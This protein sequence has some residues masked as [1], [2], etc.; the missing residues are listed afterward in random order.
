MV[1]VGGSHIAV[2]IC[3]SPQL[4]LTHAI[5]TTLPL[6]GSTDAFL[7]ALIRSSQQ[8][9]GNLHT[10][11][12]AAI[13]IAG[14]F[15]YPKGISRMR[16][17]LEYLYGFGMKAAIANHFGWL[18]E[19]VQFLN[20]ADA[21]LLGEIGTGAARLAT[22]SVG[23]TLGT[24]IG[25]AFALNGQLVTYGPGVPERGEVWD[26]P[27]ESGIVEDLISTRA[28]QANYL[29]R[30]SVM[31]DVATIAGG[32]ATDAAARVVFEEFGRQLGRVLRHVTAQFA[33]E[34]IVIGG[35]IARSSHLFLPAA[36]A[37]L[38]FAGTCL[39]VSHQL[40][41]APLIGA[42]VSWFGHT[43][44]QSIHETAISDAL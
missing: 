23:I 24:G 14:P 42:A 29:R 19:R 20:D 28:L 11:S 2:A 44:T 30:T 43:G 34:V 12:G 16:H 27:Y 21:F 37:E 9:Q 22:R 31:L 17:K 15:D 18:P 7:E 33:P 6:Q 4:E 40:D 8:L 26:L 41:N 25:S 35:G 39:Q 10:L 36:S 3:L 38:Q 32:A 13:A 1:D 5:C